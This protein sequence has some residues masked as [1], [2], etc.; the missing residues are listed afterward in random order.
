MQAKQ[1]QY[2]SDWAEDS[3][4][5]TWDR[6]LA[7]TIDTLINGWLFIF[8]FYV[9]IFSEKLIPKYILFTSI[10]YFGA[11]LINVVIMINNG[12]T[13]GKWLFGIRVVDSKLSPVS[14]DVLIK[15]ELYVFTKGLAFGIPLINLIFI[16]IEHLRLLYKGQTSWDEKLNT[17]LLYRTASQTQKTL[18][19]IGFILS[20]LVVFFNTFFLMVIVLNFVFNNNNVYSKFF[21]FDVNFI[22]ESFGTVL[23]LVIVALMWLTNSL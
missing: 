19:I 1:E 5:R 21:S 10:W 6:Y 11:A 4:P 8:I 17:K 2:P 15:R 23:K 18:R 22:V 20:V 16:Y 3:V 7:R 12:T 14:L 13:L 9:N